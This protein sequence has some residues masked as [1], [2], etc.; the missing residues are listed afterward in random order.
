MNYPIPQTKAQLLE[1]LD[2]IRAGVEA[3]D[4]FEGFINYLMPTHEDPEC[5]FMVLARW[6]E[7]NSMGQGSMA[8][9]GSMEPP[10]QNPFMQ[11]EGGSN[12]G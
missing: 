1:I 7:G 6:R 11:T 4:S 10:Q 5:D 2:T 12:D 9:V 3:D 8:S